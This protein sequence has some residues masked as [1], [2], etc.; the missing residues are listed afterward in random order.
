MHQEDEDV[1]FLGHR[2]PARVRPAA[3]PVAAALL[4]GR[5]LPHQVLESV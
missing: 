4:G 1:R 3:S 2:Q 5:R